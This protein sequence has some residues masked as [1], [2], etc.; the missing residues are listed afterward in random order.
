MKKVALA[1]LLLAVVACSLLY[2]V[3]VYSEEITP[4][5]NAQQLIRV[6]SLVD[7]YGGSFELRNFVYAVDNTTV[8]LDYAKVAGHGQR[9]GATLSTDYSLEIRGL[10]IVQE[11]PRYNRIHLGNVTYSG[12]LSIRT[13]EEGQTAIVT[14][15]LPL[16]QVLFRR[17]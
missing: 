9:L 14:L 6:L 7:A 10:D 4:D 2:P 8:L 11:Y 5:E 15:T 13:T 12:T 3:T 16:Y 17:S 1:S